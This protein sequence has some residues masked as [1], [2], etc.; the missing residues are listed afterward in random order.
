MSINLTA[1]KK[2]KTCFLVRLQIDQ[3]RTDPNG[4]YSSQILRF[5]DDQGSIT[6]N[7]DGQNVT[8]TGLGR[9]VNITSSRS[10][11]KAN[12]SQ[13]SITLS[14][15]PST[16]IAEI[17]NSKIK[18]SKVNVYRALYD[19]SN[20][21]LQID[22]NPVGRFFGIVTNF[23]LDETYDIEKKSSTNT[24]TL[25]CS[26]WIDMLKYKVTGRRTNPFDQQNLY[27]GD[28]SMDRVPN[29]TGSNYNFGDAP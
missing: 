9:L 26:S 28:T 11:L 22:N 12:E 13:V 21:I 5:C 27:P 20:Q 6:V 24:I 8:Y 14:G 17:L 10:E 1:Y 16:S 7:E 25:T 19:Q 3:Y 2:I 29:L 23:N 15:V 18:G 4:N